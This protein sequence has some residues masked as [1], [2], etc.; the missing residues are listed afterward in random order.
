[1]KEFIQYLL[2]EII[3]KPEKL[4][5]DEQEDNGIYVYNITADE[6]DMGIIIGKQGKNINALRNIVKA[7]AIKENKRVKIFVR[8]LEESSQNQEENFEEEND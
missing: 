7:K 2:T 4:F 3:T 8:D 5:V 1:M 6:E